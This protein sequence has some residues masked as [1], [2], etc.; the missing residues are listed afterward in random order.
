MEQS[1]GIIITLYITY[2]EC[3][4]YISFTKDQR[5]SRC[6]LA[7]NNIIIELPPSMCEVVARSTICIINVTLAVSL[8]QLSESPP[9]TQ[10]GCT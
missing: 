6:W 5:S 8:I 10:T 1:H 3:R 9:S 4:K 2:R 7:I